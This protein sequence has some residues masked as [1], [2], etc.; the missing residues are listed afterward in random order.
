MKAILILLLATL[1]FTAHATDNPLQA[2]LWKT[3]PL[4]LLADDA[5]DPLLVRVREALAQPANREA[6]AERD[7]VLYTVVGRA[8]QR[9]DQPLDPIA[10]RR[11]LLALDAGN[12]RPQLI[13][14]GKD[15]GKKIQQGADADLRVIFAAIDR[16]PMRQGE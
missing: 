12:R 10:T 7:M 3:R 5:D 8:G 4:I 14:L 6:F 16:M 15:G 13:L 11:L 2:E 9:N 1:A